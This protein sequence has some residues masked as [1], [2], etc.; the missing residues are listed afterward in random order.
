M[1]RWPTTVGEGDREVGAFTEMDV[2]LASIFIC[3]KWFL[4]H[5]T[6]MDAR[7]IEGRAFPDPYGAREPRICG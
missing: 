2:G 1:T 5:R 6:T 4:Q 3:P 7:R